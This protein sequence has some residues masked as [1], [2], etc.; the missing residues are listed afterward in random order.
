[1]GTMILL[2]KSGQ[3]LYM[4]SLKK[5][6]SQSE[7]RDLLK[8]YSNILSPKLTLEDDFVN[9]ICNQFNDLLKPNRIVI[10]HRNAIKTCR[11]KNER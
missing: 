4:N 5:T 1:M 10:P 3:R 8:C 6:S 2:S 11:R 7:K 9:Q